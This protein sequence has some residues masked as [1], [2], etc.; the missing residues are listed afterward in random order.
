M[1][2]GSQLAGEWQRAQYVFGP[3]PRLYS[4]P[5]GPETH[6]FQITGCCSAIISAGVGGGDV[7][8]GVTSNEI[9][10]HALQSMATLRRAKIDKIRTYDFEVLKWGRLIIF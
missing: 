10:W 2:E 9:A 5:C 1:A 8:V 3:F 4:D 7:G 6:A